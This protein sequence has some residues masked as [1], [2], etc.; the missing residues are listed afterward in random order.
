MFHGMRFAN[1]LRGA[2]ADGAGVL[3][4]SGQPDHILGQHLLFGGALIDAQAG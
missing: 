3:G 4:K 1:V 2:L